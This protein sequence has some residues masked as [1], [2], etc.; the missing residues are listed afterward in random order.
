MFGFFILNI[1]IVFVAS[2]TVYE[3]GGVSAS[4]YT[5][6]RDGEHCVRMTT[7]P[8]YMNLIKSLRKP[9]QPAA[10][11]FLRKQECGFDGSYPM[12]CCF[13]G[14]NAEEM[15][16]DKINAGQEKIKDQLQDK[17]DAFNTAFVLSNMDYFFVRRMLEEMKN[18]TKN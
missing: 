8:S 17:I 12:V 15:S 13:N 2:V 14:S 18:N 3:F 5:S 1:L 10:V 16:K 7:C 6:C 4:T 9:L 11:K